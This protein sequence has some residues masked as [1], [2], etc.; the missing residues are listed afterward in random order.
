M[1]RQVASL[2]L[3]HLLQHA[4]GLAGS[5]LAARLLGVELRGVVVIV[6]VA[7]T[8]GMTVAQLGLPQALNYNLSRA[9]GRKEVLDQSLAVCVRL[10]P[11]IILCAVAFFSLTY[12]F[13]RTS[14][15]NGLSTELI[16]ASF[17]FTLAMTGQ[18]VVVRLLLGLHDYPMRNIVNLMQPALT[19]T[20]LAGFWISGL[21]L[22]PLH[23]AAG[24]VGFT[25]L[26][27]GVGA[28]YIR[29][30]YKPARV[31]VPA[32]WKQDYVGYGLKF[33]PSLLVNLL[34][35]RAD[36]FLVNAFLGTAAVGLYATGVAMTEVLL[37]LPHT[38]NFV[39]FNH[40]SREQDE[41]K[42]VRLTARTL[43]FSLY[44][45]GIGAAIL[46]VL[47][48]VLIPWLY[49]PDFAPGVP[50]ALWLLPGM[51]ALTVV[52]VLTHAVA[53][54]GR[55]EYATYTTLVGLAATLALDCWLIPR[56]GIVGAAWASLAGYS[57]WGAAV[58][59]LYIRLVRITPMRL[60]LD[61]LA[62]PLGWLRQR[63]QERSARLGPDSTRDQEEF[64]SRDS[65]ELDVHCDAPSRAVAISER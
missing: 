11:W 31:P 40:I 61:I 4:L 12:L 14:F 57:I 1:L 3:N 43:G 19:V 17:L 63:A 33:Y 49:G 51:M 9:R 10:L 38:V 59:V 44:A 8:L 13:G 41:G 45:V 18:E 47:L 27:V 5:I 46:A 24:Y 30:K 64:Q 20:M 39:F 60:A 16:L 2:F 62:A 15:F 35:Y 34:N 6:A 36:T 65:F 25:L 28:Y 55:P 21:Q 22:R 23:L 48:P 32:E 50:A 58:A 7:A 37:F 26:A 42:R 54:C 53:G 56:Y 29:S 52:K